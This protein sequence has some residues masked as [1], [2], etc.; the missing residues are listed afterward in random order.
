MGVKQVLQSIT[1]ADG[2][3]DA[4]IMAKVSERIGRK[5]VAVDWAGQSGAGARGFVFL[6]VANGG[7]PEKVPFRAQAKRGIGGAFEIGD[8]IVPYTEPSSDLEVLHNRIDK[9]LSRDG[10]LKRVGK[11]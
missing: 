11:R 3:T 8:W 2:D 9:K 5:I 10:T 1:L 7:E 6:E 4:S